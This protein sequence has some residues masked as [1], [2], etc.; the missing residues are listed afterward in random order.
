[1]TS[2]EYSAPMMMR[3]LKMALALALA[4]LAA[5]AEE[6]QSV[7][8]EVVR[9]L[10]IASAQGPFETW[11]DVRV[12]MPR[13]V[14]W[15]LV[16]PDE[17]NARSFRRS[18]WIAIVGR[19]AGVAVCGTARTPEVLVLRLGG[20]DETVLQ[21]LRDHGLDIRPVSERWADG[22]ERYHVRAGAALDDQILQRRLSCTPPGSR[23]GRSCDTSYTLTIRPPY[24]S[25]P[26]TRECRAP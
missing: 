13:S 11:D 18:G 14:N 2:G 6:V 8:A 20:E 9:V 23:A 17:P 7:E 5:R 4:P 16:P 21:G 25:A 24:R 1:M 22:E 26:A 3:T 10:A 19:Q 12:A 15:H